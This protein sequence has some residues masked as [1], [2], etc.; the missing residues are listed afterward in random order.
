MNNP[1]LAARWRSWAPYLLS[2]LRI[3]AAFIFI[4]YGS[5][6][7]LGLPA[8]VMPGGGTAP[9]ASLP[10][11]AGA[12]ELVGGA[13]LL[14]GLFTRPVAFLVAGEMAVAYFMGHAPRGFWPVLNEGA[15]AILFCFIWLY[16]SSAGPG[17]WSLDAILR[18]KT[19]AVDL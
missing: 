8:P 19:G 10:G 15:P 7:L 14:F 9:L 4:Q 16:I 11:F 17:P 3:L 13:F 12:L 5:T 1:T 2:I 6:K 18:R